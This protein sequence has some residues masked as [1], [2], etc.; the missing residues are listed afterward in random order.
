MPAHVAILASHMDTCRL[1][2][3]ISTA[4]L[5]LFLA[6]SP[7]LAGGAPA[8][9]KPGPYGGLSEMRDG[10]LTLIPP[11]EN[12]ASAEA[13]SAASFPFWNHDGMTVHI[14]FTLGAAKGAGYELLVGLVPEGARGGI[15]GS[16]N[17][18][19]V[20][21][22]RSA[23]KPAITVALCRKEASSPDPRIRGSQFGDLVNY[24]S[25]PGP[26]VPLPGDSLD[27]T[28][29]VND[30]TVGA[31]VGPGFSESRPIGLSGTHWNAAELVVRCKN[32]DD[33]RGSI[34]VDQI[35]VDCPQQL[36]NFV[37]P[38]DLRSV[39][40]MGF[41]DEV[42]GDD[43]GGW[44]DQG[45]NDLRNIAP[46]FQVVR[47]IPFDIVD[48][49][50]NGGKSCLMLYSKNRT[51]FPKRSGRVAIHREANSLIFLHSA[52]WAQSKATA[53]HYVVAYEDGTTVSIPIEIGA[54]IDDWWGMRPVSDPQAGVL[55]TVKNDFSLSGTVGIY[56]YRWVNPHPSKPIASLEF[57]SGEGDPVVGI[58]AVS[59][60]RP[61]IGPVQEQAL[62]AAFR[63]EA[64][65]DLKRFPP[66]ADK[67]SDQVRLDA[68]KPPGPYFFSVAGSYSGGGGGKAMLDLPGYAREIQSVGGISRFP[69]GLEISF[70]FWPYEAVDWY[71]VLGAKGGTYGAI[72]R[73]Y[74]K[75]GGPQD[76]LS[77]QTMLADTKAKGLKLDLLLNCHAMFNGRDFVYVK[78]LP[79]DK[80]KVQNP[81][82]EGV[83]S[84]ANLDA[85][86]KNNATLVDYVVRHGYTDTVAFWEMDN[87]RWDMLGAEY[88]EVVAAHVKMLRARLPK[89]KVI[90][91]LGELGPYTSNPEGSHAIAWSRDLLKRLQELGMNGKIDYFAP[92]L[93]P[94]LFDTADEITQNYLEDWSVRNI[95]RS[96]DYMSG[97]LDRYGFR[98]SRFFVSEWGA[99]S[100]GL[101][102]QSR[103][104]LITSM[105]AAIGTA[106]D[107]MAIYSHPRVQGSTW[108]QFWGSSFVSRERSM[109]ISRWGEQ[110]LFAVPGRGFVTTPPLQ[111]MKM[112]TAFGR[113]GQLVPSMLDVPKGVHCLCCRTPAGYTYF[114]VNSTSSSVKLSVAGVVRRTSLFAPSVLATSI[115]R[116]GGY[117]DQ[118]GEIH[119][120]LPRSFKDAILPP[121]SVNVVDAGR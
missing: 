14:R 23:T 66:D 96:L 76:T 80:M 9:W 57:Q 104:E 117:G 95:R 28:L 8:F 92:H 13:Q 113:S 18:V 115:G 108:H 48:P 65:A 114:V 37:E 70:Y 19:G 43:K 77:Y 110:T 61:G 94:N 21:V 32:V 116:Y 1:G 6:P 101:G 7:I 29:N 83:F 31:Q 103:N 71:P 54:Q 56:G 107:M 12:W 118:A 46:G 17:A 20:S 26:E 67:V 93:Y 87:E 111:A 49:D 27:V 36:A 25:W 33:G 63:R 85:I 50:S 34:T 121:Y 75:Y 15:Q 102:D 112:L 40:N 55:L 120:I 73:W 39:V 38:L 74:Y 84:R 109:P 42:K 69:Y 97:M 62:R 5:L 58:L 11:D 35:T 81:L 64:V 53:A 72:E 4:A 24:G 91:C 2:T 47:S 52:A 60:V 68:P 86:V 41:R 88:A 105:A 100:D 79:E 89:A 16:E 30:E 45:E 82:D 51:Y 78:T 22:V 119:E 98:S 99:Q 3:M 59:L 106:K 90:V 44:T 10:K